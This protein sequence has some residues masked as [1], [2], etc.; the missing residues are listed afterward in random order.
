MGGEALDSLAA[1]GKTMYIALLGAVTFEIALIARSWSWIF[2]LFVFFSYTMVFALFL[3]L[4]A[5]E[6]ALKIPDPDLYGVGPVLYRNPSFWLQIILCYC[7]T[8]GYRLVE[9]AVKQTFY[10]EDY[11][12]LSERDKIQASR[13]PAWAPASCS[14][15]GTSWPRRQTLCAP[16]RPSRSR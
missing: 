9:K 15:C 16:P 14:A 10:P 1:A 7:I 5:L 2:F 6:E 12:I 8:V 11:D 13:R 3:I 4:P